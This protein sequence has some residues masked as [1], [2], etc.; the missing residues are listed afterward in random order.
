MQSVACR[1][2]ALLALITVTAVA[3]D[4]D[5][6]YEYD[7]TNEALNGERIVACVRDRSR[8]SL[9]EVGQVLKDLEVYIKEK[10]REKKDLLFIHDLIVKAGVMKDVVEAL[11]MG[12]VMD[13]A[14]VIAT[15]L[16][17]MLISLH[18]LVRRLSSGKIN[19]QGIIYDLYL[20]SG[21]LLDLFT[22]RL[23]QKIFSIADEDIKM[24]VWNSLKKIDS[25]FS[26]SFY[27]YKVCIGIVA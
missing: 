13:V 22:G 17:D 24:K 8:A 27:K 15:V 12:N 6:Y 3:S 2:L 11:I 4:L 7:Q 1:V 10:S 14:P 9:Y 16:V 21:L 26:Y 20:S 18:D 23:P 25:I 5:D 19:I